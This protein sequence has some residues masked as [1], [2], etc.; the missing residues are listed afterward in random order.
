[1]PVRQHAL[2]DTRNLLPS[3]ELSLALSQLFGPIGEQK[4]WA[5]TMAW[6]WGEIG[7]EQQLL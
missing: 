2:T 3:I 1:M 7:Q 6:I 5:A 4:R